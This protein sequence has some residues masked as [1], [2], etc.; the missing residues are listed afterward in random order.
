MKYVIITC[1][2][3]PLLALA[4]TT[5]HPDSPVETQIKDK[6]LKF[7]QAIE[8]KDVAQLDNLLHNDFRVVANQYPTVEKLSLLPKELYL[9]LI[10]S[11]KIGGTHYE[12]TFDHISV[13]D[14]SATAVVTFQAEES[15]MHLTLL[16]I[17]KEGEWRII[18]DMALIK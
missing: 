8:A 12:V 3:M 11:K 2:C 10:Q 5:K 15:T 16:L 18:E 17:E 1:I 14:H 9:S 6:V 13:K 4:F 7:A